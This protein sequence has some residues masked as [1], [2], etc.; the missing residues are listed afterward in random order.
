M[1]IA[2]RDEM[3]YSSTIFSDSNWSF[4]LSILFEE[5]YVTSRCIIVSFAAFWKSSCLLIFGKIGWIKQT[6]EIITY[7]EGG[8]EYWK[9]QLLHS[10]FVS[11]DDCK[12]GGRSR[13][14]NTRS[15]TIFLSNNIIVVTFLT[16]THTMLHTNTRET[17]DFLSNILCS[18][19]LK[20]WICLCTL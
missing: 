12:V 2:I 13:D 18:S 1:L 9:T 20:M 6:V 17:R 10:S 16:L 14:N 7:Q 15:H 4:K 19:W 11:L 8:E 3:F 5:L